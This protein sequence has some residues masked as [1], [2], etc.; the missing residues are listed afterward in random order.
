MNNILDNLKTFTQHGFEQIEEIGDQVRGY[1]PFCNGDKFFINP[2]LKT[3]DCKHCVREG[4]YQKFLQKM[5]IFCQDN[6]TGEIVKKLHRD[7][8]LSSRILKS[9]EIGYNPKTEKYTIPMYSIDKSKVMNLY[10]YDPNAKNKKYKM[11]GTYGGDQELIGLDRYNKSSKVIWL[12]EGHWDYLAMSEILDTMEN[13]HETV[14][15][16]PGVGQMKDTWVQFF[17][18][19]H[20][21]VLYDNDYDDKRGGKIVNPS[22]DGQIKVF[23]K[24]RSVVAEMKFIHWKD[25][26]KDGYDIRDLYIDNK[27]D[28]EE[29]YEFIVGNL[30]PYPQ[31]MDLPDVNVQSPS[32]KY[33]GLGLMPEQVYERYTKW[34]RLRNTEVL[35]IFYGAMLANRLPGDPIWLM[36]V[37]PS[38]CGKSEV[39]MSI[40]DAVDIFSIDTLTKNTLVSGAMGVGGSDPS[41][42][43]QIDGKILAI[44]DMTTIL[45]MQSN[46]RDEIFSQLRSA[47]DG[48][49]NKPFGVGILR[50]YTSKFG[51][52]AGVT[53][54][55]ELYTEGHTALGERFLRYPFPVN[56]TSKGRADVLHKA[57]DNIRSNQKDLMHK[58]LR[59]T[60]TEVLNYNYEK[61]PEMSTEYGEELV[62]LAEWTSIMRGTVTRDKY[63]K[64]ITHK[65]FIEIGTR[66]VTQFGKLSYGI[67][68]FKRLDKLT[69]DVYDTVR[70]V[71]KGS[72]PSKNEDIIRKLYSRY[73]D[74]KRETS[75]DQMTELIKLPTVT[76]QRIAEN[77]FTLGALVKTKVV[78]TPISKYCLSDELIHLIEKARIY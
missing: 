27:H 41:L 2:E 70:E 26:L 47:Y 39:I 73:C 31:G 74:N 35:D 49:F 59:E 16:V 63:T 45:D 66:L 51:I 44:K 29:T 37:G 34:L 18:G 10:I 13:D 24:L 9:F 57:L 46:D 21:F 11:I 4:G 77:L 12:A 38:G 75:I 20:V 23:N 40:K 52:M 68:M 43:P 53:R 22:R 69:D 3:W 65:A 76:V 60:G 71:A 42:I 15:A 58:E 48:E 5:N 72:V 54:A 32:E 56:N 61:I 7:R 30:E 19:K 55:I 14:L 6:F 28:A 25:G 1:C 17:A 78:G 62:A 67:A 8:S 36:L 33:T 50:A 64:E